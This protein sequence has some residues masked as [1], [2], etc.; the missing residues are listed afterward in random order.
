MQA[1]PA[2]RAGSSRC[3]WIGPRPVDEALVSQLGGE[4]HL[5]PAVCRLLAVRGYGS[6]DAARLFLRPRLEQLHAPDGLRDLHRAVERLASAI[7]AGETIL[8]HGDYDVDGMCSTTLLTRSLRALGATVIPFVPHRVSDGYDLGDAGVRAAFELNARV[9][10]TAD[11]GTSARAAIDRLQRAG[12]DVIVTDHHLPSAELPPAF[13]V[14]NP[15]QPG[16]DYPDKDLAAVGVA[17]KLMLALTRAVGGNENVV[18]G[19]LDLVALATVADIAPLRGENRVFVRYGLKLLSQSNNL[20]LRA[21]IRAAGLDGKP[22]TAG[23]VGYILAPRL[24]AVGRL[25]HA[26]RGIELLLSSTE[27]EANAIARELEELNRRRQEMDRETLEQARSMVER[28]DLESTFGIVLAADGWHPGV[29]GIVA[30]RIVETYGRPAVLVALEGGEGKGS[31]R[32]ISAFDL[33]SGIAACQ[34]LLMRFGGHRAAAGIT[35]ARDQVDAFSRCFNE[36]ARQRLTSEDLVPELRLDLELSLD[37]VTHELEA[38]LRHLEPC[39]VGNPAPVL[40]ARNVRLAGPPRLV[41]KNGL[42]LRLATAA[43]ELEAIGWDMASRAKELDPAL[44][45]DIA[46]RLERDDFRGEPRLQAKIA[47]FRTG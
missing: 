7:R 30:S 38:V 14:L 23:R 41:G 46:F 6:G 5:P 9:V 15:R 45:L 8:V 44:P 26:L 16:C 18:Y 25:G 43:G 11:C 32:S 42:R 12:I 36:V 17:F 35:I 29:I 27:H 28:L 40:L 13:A 21:L 22:L 39:G 2:A 4:L 34:D 47:D 19:M 31:G 24:N 3:R 10:L 33:H 1:D 20:G 37:E